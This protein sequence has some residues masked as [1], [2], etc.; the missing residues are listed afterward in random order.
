MTER[1]TEQRANRPP[2][3]PIFPIG[4]LPSARQE[5]MIIGALDG[6]Q[7]KLAIA[8]GSQWHLFVPDSTA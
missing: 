8:D 3:L 5:G 4:S 2:G 1:T 6:S 7:L